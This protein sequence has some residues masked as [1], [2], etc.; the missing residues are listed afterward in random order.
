[1]TSKAKVQIQ[2]LI[3]SCDTCHDSFLSG[4]AILTSAS[5][6]HS[7]HATDDCVEA[8]DISQKFDRVEVYSGGCRVNDCKY[9]GKTVLNSSE[10]SPTTLLFRNLPLESLIAKV[11][12]SQDQLKTR[13]QSKRS[14]HLQYF[15]EN[16]VI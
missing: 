11:V 15:P 7:F 12:A 6:G 13:S 9:D 8:L 3:P 1:M 4:R 14:E 2:D 5:C 16:L 10:A